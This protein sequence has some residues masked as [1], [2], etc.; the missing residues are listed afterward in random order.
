[1]TPLF[2]MTFGNYAGVNR[3]LVLDQ[4]FI[5][6]GGVMRGRRNRI[7]R[8]A[9][10]AMIAAFV[11]ISIGAC[12][13]GNEMAGRSEALQAMKLLGFKFDKTIVS[14]EYSGS[15]K[16]I[17]VTGPMIGPKVLGGPIPPKNGSTYTQYSRVVM[18]FENERWIVAETKLR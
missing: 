16:V 14:T 2:C 11:L 7:G 15:P 17:I 6:Q 12:G 13:N 3:K 5:E 4:R 8:I 10:Y 1:M 9:V 18:K